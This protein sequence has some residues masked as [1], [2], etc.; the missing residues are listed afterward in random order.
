VQT[1]KA[2]S[3]ALGIAWS[4]GF[5]MDPAHGNTT[6]FRF[7]NNLNQDSGFTGDATGST[8]PLGATT[9]PPTSLIQFGMS[10]ILDT[11]RLQ[12]ALQASESEGLTKTLSNPRISTSDNIP[13]SIRS[14]KEIAYQILT[15]EGPKT[16]FKQATISLNVT[17]HVTADQRVSLKVRATDDT[18][19]ERIDFAGGFAF[20]FNKNEATSSLLVDNGATVVIGGVRKRTESV[21]ETKVPFLGDIPVLGWLFKRRTENVEPQTLELLIFI[22]PRIL[23]EPRQTRGY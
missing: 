11:F 2:F 10:D 7:P 15:R 8:P 22:T 12:V 14:G 16:E 3:R 4:Q 1:K 9:T 21:A 23:E 20:P 13:A 18:R 19:G 6:G 17:P 5:D